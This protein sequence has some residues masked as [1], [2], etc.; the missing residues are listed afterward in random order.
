MTI[1]DVIEATLDNTPYDEL[2]ILLEDGVDLKIAPKHLYFTGTIQK[3]EV[4]AENFCV[5]S[6][7]DFYTNYAGRIPAK[8]IQESYL[9]IERILLITV[10][11]SQ[12]NAARSRNYV[13]PKEISEETSIQYRFI[14]GICR[15]ERPIGRCY[16]DAHKGYLNTALLKKHNC[17]NRQG[18]ATCTFLIKDETHPYWKQRNNIKQKKAS[19]KEALK[20]GSLETL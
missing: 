8:V 16:C 17:L 9:D 20:T 10:P 5:I 4:T 14:D 1:S 13:S 7:H 2:C 6:G 19:R 12:Y 11:A 18:H 15:K 3:L